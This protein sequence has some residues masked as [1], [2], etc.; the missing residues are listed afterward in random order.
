MAAV[1]L[2]LLTV[3][4][5]LHLHSPQANLYTAYEKAFIGE[6]LPLQMLVKEQR[7]I[8]DA[9]ILNA[10]ANREAWQNPDFKPK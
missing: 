8:T 3:F 6:N 2:A 5:Y 9:S 10:I 7:D 4:A 1:T